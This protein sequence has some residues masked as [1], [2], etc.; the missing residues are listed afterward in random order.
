MDT[1]L[2]ADADEDAIISKMRNGLLTVK[3]GKKSY[4]L[5]F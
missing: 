5:F 2:P 1:P 3:I 4:L